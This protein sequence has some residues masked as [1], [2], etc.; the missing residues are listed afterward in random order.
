MV[1][2]VIV[3]KLTPV[4]GGISEYSD[5]PVE[6]ADS[7]EALKAYTVRVYWVLAVM[8]PASSQ[9]TVPAAKSGETATPAVVLTR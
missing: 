1:V 9:V 4:G 6:P 2:G 8:P 7:P 3:P 5:W